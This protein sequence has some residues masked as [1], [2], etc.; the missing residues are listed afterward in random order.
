MGR[1]R[2]ENRTQEFARAQQRHEEAA[3]A[4]AAKMLGRDAQGKVVETRSLKDLR[5]LVDKWYVRLRTK[6]EK[7]P[8]EITDL[9]EVEA[10]IRDGTIPMRSVRSSTHIIL[11]VR[12]L[13]HIQEGYQKEI[14]RTEKALKIIDKL[15]AALVENRNITN[16]ELD[17]ATKRL[18]DFHGVLKRKRI[19]IKKVT[20]KKVEHAIAKLEESKGMEGGDRAMNIS[21]GCALVAAARLWAGPK[22]DKVIAGIVAYDHER[23]CAL[24]AYR[25]KWVLGQLSRFAEAPKEIFEYF[26]QDSQKLRVLEEIRRLFT[27]EAGRDMREMTDA[28]GWKRFLL[29]YIVQNNALFHIKDRIREGAEQ[30]VALME[31]G[32]HVND[33][34]KIDYLVGHYAWLYKYMR[35]YFEEGDAKK[36]AEWKKKT[37]DKIKFLKVF[38]NSNKPRFI[39]D[40][41]SDNADPYLAPV[42]EQLRPAVEAFERTNLIT[43][44]KH[45]EAARDELKAILEGPRPEAA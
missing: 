17:E 1:D 14:K 27:G 37:L 2:A 24:R 28:E 25:D 16:E 26:V 23:E 4:K 5:I 20:A 13:V 10:K 21:R 30:R 15:N 35:R 6:R 18:K 44:K 38:M 7:A 19:R 40:E 31:R 22:R 39:C 42:L 36:R 32:I 45:F 8:E 33:G 12:Q 11:A 29:D 3:K 9:K 43:A 34:K 41:L